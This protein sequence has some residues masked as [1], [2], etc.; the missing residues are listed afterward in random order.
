MFLIDEESK[1]IYHLDVKL[2]KITWDFYNLKNHIENNISQFFINQNYFINTMICNKQFDSKKDTIIVD[3]FREKE[4]YIN[5]N[6]INNYW[7]INNILNLYFSFNNEEQINPT[8]VSAFWKKITWFKSIKIHNLNNLIKNSFITNS[9][10][11]SE[12]YYTSCYFPYALWTYS[13]TKYFIWNVRKWID[14]S[15]KISKAKAISESIERLS[16]SIYDIPSLQ[17]NEKLTP[18]VEPFI[19][20][21]DFTKNKSHIVCWKLKSISGDSDRI[22]PLDILYYP[23]EYTFPCISNSNGMSTHTSYK[24][25]T[26]SALYEIIERDAYILMWLLK[27]GIYKID[28]KILESNYLNSLLKLK[29]KWLKFYTFIMKLDNPIPVS[30]IIIENK[31]KNIVVSWIWETIENAVEKAFEEAI[32]NISFLYNSIKNKNDILAHIDYYLKKEN[33]N[34]LNRLKELP[35]TEYKKIRIK[36]LNKTNVENIIQYYKSLNIK[37]FVHKYKNDVNKAFWRK[38]IRV[39]SDQLLPI[40]FW[41]T[42]PPQILNSK[43][44]RYFQKKFNVKNINTDLHPMW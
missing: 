3:T 9:K 39:L 4:F 38:T 23:Y 31:Q 26:H 19:Y 25:A 24:L 11:D 13:K 30:L 27:N 12:I 41:E 32:W 35:T 16:A 5:S 28:N 40:Y 36:F 34:K 21:K 18:L 20:K 33:S 37:F 29:T 10:Q 17:C 22:C 14:K 2:K 7:W 43:R 8:I 42:I 44:L 1:I 6:V 15:K